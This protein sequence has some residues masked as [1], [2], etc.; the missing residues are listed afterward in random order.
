MGKNKFKVVGLLAI[1]MFIILLFPTTTK[2]LVTS[3]DG[4]FEFKFVQNGDVINGIS[5]EGPIKIDG[6]DAFDTTVSRGSVWNVF[7]DK[8]KGFIVGLMGLLTLVLIGFGM[9]SFVSIASGTENPQKRKDGMGHLLMV[10]V[11]A[12]IFGIGTIVFAY[13]YNIF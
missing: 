9:F 4:F 13:A 11:A 7:L 10:F 6:K 12:A 2:A 5:M 1:F 3:N 8:Y